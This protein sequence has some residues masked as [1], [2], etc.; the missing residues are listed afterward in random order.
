MIN[1]GLISNASFFP[2]TLHCGGPDLNGCCRL[3]D[4]SST[5]P[6]QIS[7]GTRKFEDFQP[8]CLAD[9]QHR[10]ILRLCGVVRR[11]VL[12]GKYVPR[13]PFQFFLSGCTYFMKLTLLYSTLK[14]LSDH[15]SIFIFMYFWK[16]F[17]LSQNRIFSY[18]YNIK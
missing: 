18:Y 5:Y 14:Q 15:F 13:V 4:N 8:V 9:E 11:N 12:Q 17:S 10:W 2:N 3:N 7:C 6:V 16:N 1:A